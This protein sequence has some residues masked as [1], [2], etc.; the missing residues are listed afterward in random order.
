MEWV[1][2]FYK[3]QSDFLKECYENDVTDFNRLKIS[4][5]QTKAANSKWKILDLGWWTKCY[6]YG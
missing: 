2:K 6:S 5:I 3:K 4:Y 1:K